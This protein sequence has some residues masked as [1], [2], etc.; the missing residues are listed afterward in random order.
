M[1]VKNPVYTLIVG[2]IAIIMCATVFYAMVAYVSHIGSTPTPVA[3][4]DLLLPAM[5]AVDDQGAG[6]IPSGPVPV[7]GK[8]WYLINGQDAPSPLL[9]LPANSPCWL[10]VAGS[11]VVAT[12][13]P[14]SNLL[15]VQCATSTTDLPKP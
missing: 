1:S 5:A 12:Y 15:T 10:G 2:I 3:R 11:S 4:V 13:D 14:T 9:L 8:S 6:L 7:Q